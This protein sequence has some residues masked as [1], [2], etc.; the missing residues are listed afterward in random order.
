MNEQELE[1]NARQL[2]QFLQSNIGLIRTTAKLM[3][4][5]N[6]KQYSDVDLI[7]IIKRACEMCLKE[8]SSYE[9]DPIYSANTT[10]LGYSHNGA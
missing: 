10:P 5:I 9:F 2:K 3:K 8:N 1:K 4:G 6:L 7:K